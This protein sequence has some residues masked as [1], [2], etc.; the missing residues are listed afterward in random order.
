MTFEVI[1]GID[2]LIAVDSDIPSVNFK[3]VRYS[4]VQQY[5]S[6][7]NGF[8]QWQQQLGRLEDHFNIYVDFQY[9]FASEA[10]GAAGRWQKQALLLNEP[11]PEILFDD[12]LVTDL[13][14]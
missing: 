12:M 13:N 10:P 4:P 1:I 11:A 2:T 8:W 9:R 6:E 14:F 3:L 5:S 7:S